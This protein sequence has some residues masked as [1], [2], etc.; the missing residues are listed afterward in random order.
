[1]VRA[2]NYVDV[3]R[4]EYP[5]RKALVQVFQRPMGT[6]HHAGGIARGG[7]ELA[8][9]PHNAIIQDGIYLTRACK[10][11]VRERDSPFSYRYLPS[12]DYW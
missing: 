9:F 3:Y 6:W 10:R 7:K 5:A 8:T 4:E 12:N 11:L 1:M 2:R